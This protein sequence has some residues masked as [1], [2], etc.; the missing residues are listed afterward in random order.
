[1][2]LLG[3]QF[4]ISLIVALVI[5]K[6]SP[7]YSLA[8]WIM[9]SGLY[10]Y[11][12]PTN[13]K[14][15]T[16][17]GKPNVTTK[18]KRRK[19]VEKK[20]EQNGHVETFTI[21]CSLEITLEKSIVEEIDLYRQYKYQD[22]KWLV[23]FSFCAIIVYLLI[24]LAAKWRPQ[25]YSEEFNIGFVWC[26]LVVFF[27]IKEL[28]LLT[29]AYWK[30]DDGGERSM[31]ISFGF[32]FFIMAMGILVVDES[33]LDFGLEVGYKDFSQNLEHVYKTV[34]FSFKRAPSIWAFKVVLAFFSAFLGAILG[35]PGI[36]YANMHLDSIFFLQGKSLTLCVLNLMFFS[37]FFLLL[38]W[39][40]PLSRELL[41]VRKGKGL[42]REKLL[43]DETFLY[44]RI[45]L[46]IVGCILRL[47]ISRKLLQSHLNTASQ[48]VS[49]LKK[50]TG[51]ITN[52]ELQRTVARVFYYLS[53]AALQYIAPLILMLFLGLIL[54][55][56]TYN[57]SSENPL[58]RNA[59]SAKGNST[60]SDAKKDYARLIRSL[61]S[62]KMVN[63]TFSYIT[64]W[65]LVT[66]C[67]TS[68]F[69]MVYLK[70]LA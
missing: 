47:L 3:I 5:Q 26:T 4:V 55:T 65:S 23:D 48:K 61:F 54:R 46:L 2:A 20:V 34:N 22:Y 13:D 29:T 18:G 57:M 12:H 1:M 35:F 39:I 16:L 44:I 37:P 28:Y 66:Y 32:F 40:L 50:E 69:G 10:R 38:L 51:R 27:A 64:W 43:S 59:T 21:P 52:L 36:R 68:S 58:L 49:K 45:H 8:R 62:V 63:G 25:V 19:F 6:L 41:Y 67:M 31:T 30:S 7:F 11:L 17:A 60:E 9:C 53:A 15:R 33:I 24:E 42:I 14:L 70:Y 56:L